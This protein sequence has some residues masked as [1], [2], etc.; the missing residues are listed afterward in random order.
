MK[1]ELYIS[2]DLNC[3][4]LAKSHDWHTKRLLEPCE[5]YNSSQLLNV[6]TRTTRHSETLINLCLTTAPEKI[7][8]H[9]VIRTGLSDYD[10]IYEVRKLNHFRAEKQRAIQKRCLK[11]FNQE[12]FINDLEKVPGDSIQDVNGKSGKNCLFLLLINTLL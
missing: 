7:S 1:G 12:R 4:L 5:L 11:H 9:G 2:G 10:S 3:D 6:P 8:V